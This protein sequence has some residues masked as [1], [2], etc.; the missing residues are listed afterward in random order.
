MYILIPVKG[1]LKVNV[2][3]VIKAFIF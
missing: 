1:V 2:W 3:I